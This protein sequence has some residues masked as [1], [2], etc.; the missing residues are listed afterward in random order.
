MANGKINAA[1]VSLRGSPDPA[2]P[3]DATLALNAAVETLGASDDGTFVMVSTL[4]DGNTRIGWVQSQ[5]VDVDK[6]PPVDKPAVDKPTVDKPT[7]DKPSIVPDDAAAIP[8]GDPVPFAV[9][10]GTDAETFWP[11]ATT[12]PQALVIS[13]LTPDGKTIGREGR[14][15]LAVRSDGARHHVGIDLFCNA[16]ENVVACAPGTIVHFSHFLDSHGEQ[17]FQLLVDHGPVVINYGEVT[18]DSNTVFKW[19]LGD[20][21]KAGQAI[22]LVGATQMLHFE[23]YVAGTKVNHRWMVGDPRPPEVLNPTKL[24]LRIAATGQRK[25]VGLV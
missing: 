17:T 8:P 9:L 5:F 21:V 7:I 3:A 24:L 23:T 15:F 4:I 13:R 14:R 20:R 16:G 25:G 2:A 12:D 22:G 1:N 6:T 19:K 10:G 11:V 18:S